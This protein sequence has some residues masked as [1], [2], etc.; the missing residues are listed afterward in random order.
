[1]A[2]NIELTDID[3]HL[4]LIDDDSRQRY[5]YLPFK[6]TIVATW[7]TN[8]RNTDKITYAINEWIKEYKFAG[9]YQKHFSHQIEFEFESDAIAFKL[10]WDGY[11]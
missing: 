2:L 10:I 4:S 11:E 5:T 3:Y 8:W 9:K 7:K 1:M 6:P